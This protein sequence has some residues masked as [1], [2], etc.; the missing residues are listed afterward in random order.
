MVDENRFAGLADAENSDLED[1]TDVT[2][3]DPDQ[4]TSTTSPDDD[5]EVDTSEPDEGGPAFSFDETTA[6]SIYVREETLDVLEDTELEIELLLRQEHDIRDITGREVMDA[7][8]RVAAKDPDAVVNQII[9][10]RDGHSDG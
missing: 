2:H 7:V 4:E 5:G 10:E 6:K 9:A 1:E 8:L 3:D